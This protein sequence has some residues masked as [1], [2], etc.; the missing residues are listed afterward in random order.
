MHS[1]KLGNQTRESK[2]T[3]WHRGC[4]NVKIMMAAKGLTRLSS[5]KVNATANFEIYHDAD[6]HVLEQKVTQWWNDSKTLG[7]AIRRKWF[8]GIIKD[9]LG[10][11]ILIAISITLVSTTC[12]VIH[13]FVTYTSITTLDQFTDKS[14]GV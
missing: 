8:L 4:Q 9:C 5:L 12:F 11:N 13:H 14:K 3:T 10:I 7:V 1:I 2:K 6:I